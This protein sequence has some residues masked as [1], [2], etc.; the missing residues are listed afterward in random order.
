MIA[1]YYLL[2][3]VV[4]IVK[5][6]Y[7]EHNK[8]HKAGEVGMFADVFASN[9]NLLFG[10]ALYKINKTHYTKLRRK[11]NRP[12]ETSNKYHV[13]LSS[14]LRAMRAGLEQCDIV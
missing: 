5:D 13:R 4:K 6:T 1:Y 10:D 8:D 7:L 3:K 2:N 11:Q 14:D 9:H 12:P